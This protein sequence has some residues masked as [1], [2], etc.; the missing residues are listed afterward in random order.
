MIFE[1]RQAGGVIGWTAA[2]AAFGPFVFGVMFA[3]GNAQILYWLGFVSCMIG[4]VITW[5]YYAR[6]GAEKPSD[7]GGRWARC[8]DRAHRRILRCLRAGPTIR[9][10]HW[11]GPRRWEHHEPISDSQPRSIAEPRCATGVASPPAR[12]E[13]TSRCSWAGALVSW[14]SVT[15]GSGDSARPRSE[16]ISGAPKLRR[17]TMALCGLPGSPNSQASAIWASAIGCPAEP[18]HC[19]SKT[20]LPTAPPRC[21]NG[22]PGPPQCRRWSSR[23]RRSPPPA[24]SDRRGR[25]TCPQPG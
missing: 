8:G 15:V 3:T 9:P 12:R 13:A 22:R 10:R 2:I 6:P 23:R 24:G 5:Y 14:V 17:A 7:G 4:A 16:S 19:R 25:P 11:N 21:A 18:P 1:R 20:C